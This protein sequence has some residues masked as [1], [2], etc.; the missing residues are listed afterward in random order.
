MC[1]YPASVAIASNTYPPYT[2]WCGNS[3]VAARAKS[4]K[5]R[6]ENEGKRTKHKDWSK[7]VMLPTA[8][9]LISSAHF[10]N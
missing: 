8:I 4:T 7:Q 6:K 5:P 2:M 1:T 9:F 10:C 3:L